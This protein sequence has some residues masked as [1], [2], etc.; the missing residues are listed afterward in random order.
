MVLFR[1]VF[2]FLIFFIFVFWGNKY[3]LPNLLLLDFCCRQKTSF[4]YNRNFFV[5]EK[6]TQQN[7]YTKVRVFPESI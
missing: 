6:H 5:D 7:L 3:Y 1:Y 2:V 4:L